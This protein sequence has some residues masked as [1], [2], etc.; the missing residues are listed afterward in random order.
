M[1]SR[2][3]VPVRAAA[4]STQLEATMAHGSV[5]PTDPQQPLPR[6]RCRVQAAVRPVQRVQGHGA[7]PELGTDPKDASAPASASSLQAARAAVRAALTP[8]N[9]RPCIS[10]LSAATLAAAGLGLDRR[11]GRHASAGAGRSGGRPPVVRT[12]AELERLYGS[13]RRRRGNVGRP[14]AVSTPPCLQPHDTTEAAQ[15]LSPDPGDTVLL[16]DR[17]P[18]N[19]STAIVGSGGPELSWEWMIEGVLRQVVVNLDTPSSVVRFRQVRAVSE[20]WVGAGSSG[21]CRVR[22]SC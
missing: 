2:H 8:S 15:P 9:G 13:R 11:H 5:P 20:P 19:V 3:P 22:I 6:Q 14:N 16:C 4:R 18:A 10:A 12:L 17:A 21:R 1:P 7:P